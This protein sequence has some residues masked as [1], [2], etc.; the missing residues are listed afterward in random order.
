MCLCFNLVML[1]FI[2]PA[3]LK[4]VEA[5]E[6]LGQQ[7]SLEQAGTASTN[8][9]D[10]HTDDY[11]LLHDPLSATK[12]RPPSSHS[13]GTWVPQD[14]STALSG[15]LG[16]D[17]LTHPS[18]QLTEPQ[19]YSL[20]TEVKW[21]LGFVPPRFFFSGN[22]FPAPPADSGTLFFTS[23]PLTA[24]Q[25]RS[26]EEEGKAGAASP[27]PTGL[28]RSSVLVPVVHP[29]CAFAQAATR[30]S[31]ALLELF[32][33]QAV[34][35]RNREAMDTSH[36][37]LTRLLDLPKAAQ[38][39]TPAPAESTAVASPSP[40][41]LDTINT[42][43]AVA[44]AAA[45]EALQE[46]RRELP[47]YSCKAALLR[48][49]GEN[50][51][52]VVVGETGSGKTTQLVQYLYEAGYAAS[53]H[54]DDAAPKPSS[55]RKR[56]GPLIGCTQP[57]RLA[58]IGVSR[59]V[60]AEMGCA[61]GTTVGYS[62][63]LDD[64][65]SEATQIQFMTD[66]VLLREVTQDP[67]VSEYSVIVLDEA[68]ERSVDTD[69]LM[70]TLK[71]AVARRQGGLK[72]IVMS[73]TLD[74]EKFTRFFNH[75]PVFHVPGKMFEVKEV[76]TEEPV[77]DYVLDAVFRVCQLHLRMPLTGL[78]EESEEEGD[79][80][81]VSRHD[82][83]VFMS[84]KDDVMGTCELIHRR[85]TQLDPAARRTL[86]L[87][88]CLSEGG[89]SLSV[90]V[91]AEGVKGAPSRMVG[92]LDPTPAGFRKC[93]VAT[94]V[95]ETSLTID[96]VRYVID[97]GFVKC[98]V[99]RPHL[100]MN[101]L[102]RY[103]VSQAQA[104]QR[105][106]RAGRTAAGICFRLYTKQQWEHEMLT[107]SVPEIQ[108]SSMDS[109]V[110]LLKSVLSPHRGESK[111][112][113]EATGRRSARQPCHIS[114]SLRQF[115]FMDPPPASTI[116]RS[117]ST[118]WMLGFVDDDANIT[119][120][121]RQALELPMAPLL[122]K[123]VIDGYELGCGEEVL[124]MVSM[125]CADP[126]NLFE[127]P[128]GK[129]EEAPQRHA[130]FM[131]PMSDHLTLL[132]I[133]TQFRRWSG[134][135]GAA[136]EAHRG[137]RATQKQRDW[138]KAHFL[139]HPTLSRAEE[140]YLQLKE[141]VLR[142]RLVPKPS[143]RSTDVAPSP[144]PLDLM[145]R[146]LARSLFIHA[147]QRS[148]SNWSIYK[149]LLQPTVECHLHP[150]SSLCRQLQTPPYLVYTDLLSLTVHTSEQREQRKKGFTPFASTEKRKEKEETIAT[151]K[152]FLMVV[153]AVEPSWLVESSRGI[154]IPRHAAALKDV[155]EAPPPSAS[156][157][158][159]KEGPT[160]NRAVAGE[161]S[162][163]ASGAAAG[164]TLSKTPP[165]PSSASRFQAMKRRRNL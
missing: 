156:S 17:N 19:S 62:I 79:E 46:Q 111:D 40:A 143:S 14:D 26:G 41:S 25:S 157:L 21:N 151:Q 123:L 118:L 152:Q 148:G 106:G 149:P 135:D 9:N 12:P 37:S 121:G 113:K 117:L 138:V 65:T 129:E 81:T 27:I 50:F 155:S 23:S 88:P 47:I 83:L 103:P 34:E 64:C 125:L 2:D 1:S 133:F 87:L 55:R 59:R 76:Y 127:V 140:I 158:P 91:L 67:D 120:L 128:K 61:L 38:E 43:N 165:A 126:K 52:T 108:R 99:Y 116:Q 137:A 56:R 30:G 60:S 112:E 163:T 68:H 4:Q 54:E 7:D 5:E 57:R 42:T 8:D 105:K 32:Q 154:F 134:G 98:C 114:S 85:L 36:S 39:R 150:S 45:W 44:D 139:H 142:M 161:G 160:T 153:T 136:A 35:R 18:A 164:L 73:A 78:V 28:S 11:Y 24:G 71:A 89:A 115:E 93:V 141:K 49:I 13:G 110:L 97:S 10:F 147:A 3:K 66:G 96:G 22:D 70:G 58:A 95:A 92:V 122:A 107:Q 90:G 75:A 74:Y 84:G 101:T 33:L 72:L 131:V 31:A 48:L 53:P 29:Q 16:E 20:S 69:V 6:S 159:T 119:L 104:N 145:R 63:H 162:N 144:P 130:R 109:V 77:V 100:G 82:I 124:K 94:N 132:N 146:C 15:F 51:I 80:K 102:Q 86:L